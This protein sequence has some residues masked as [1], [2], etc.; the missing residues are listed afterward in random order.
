MLARSVDQDAASV[1]AGGVEDAVEPAA[2]SALAWTAA[3]RSVAD[4]ATTSTWLAPASAS[5]DCEAVASPG[6]DRHATAR[7][8]AANFEVSVERQR[9]AFI[10]SSFRVR[11]WDEKQGGGRASVKDDGGRR[12]PL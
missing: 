12:V 11:S 4:D 2:G 10:V 1:S 3:G 9:T 7:A 6:N 5:G 8:T